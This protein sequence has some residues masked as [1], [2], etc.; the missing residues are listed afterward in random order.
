MLRCTLTFLTWVWGP[1]SPFA[2]TCRVE[3]SGQNRP[4]P[5]DG[6]RVWRLA[7]G[8][9]LEAPRRLQT[10]RAPQLPQREPRL[11]EQVG[12]Q[13]AA[14]TIPGLRQDTGCLCIASNTHCL[15]YPSPAAP[16]INT[17]STFGELRYTCLLL[18]RMTAMG[19][20]FA[21]PLYL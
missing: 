4:H 10:P 11:P 15:R 7:C 16:P 6:A 19:H 18:C 3:A 2:G 14:R 21:K 12:C 9:L 8:S 13:S 5:K 20:T 17:V 1:P